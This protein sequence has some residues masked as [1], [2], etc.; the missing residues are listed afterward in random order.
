MINNDDILNAKVLIV[1]DQKTLVLILEH[2]LKKSG[3]TNI[4]STTDSTK[5]TSLYEEYQPDLILLDLMMPVK[6]GFQVLEELRELSPFDFP[7]VMVLTG[8]A[9]KENRLKALESGAR[10]F[11]NKP[12]DRLEIITRMRNL[13]NDQL[14][15]KQIRDQ[16]KILEER[17]RERTSELRET[18]LEIIRR[19]GRA[20]EYRDN[21]TGLH[22][23]RMSN[24]S[25]ILGCAAGMS[26]HDSELVLYASPL[27][28]IG[29]IAIPDSILQ[30]RG[31]LTNDE[32][33]IMKRHT[34]I[35]AK[36]LEGDSSE[37]VQLAREIALNHHEKWDGSGYPAGKKGEEIPFVGR[38]CS[39]CDVFDSLTSPRSYKKAWP[40]EEAID[41]IK[42]Q[43]GKGFDPDLVN[44]FLAYL[45]E[46]LVIKDKYKETFE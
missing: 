6:D 32:W 23:I 31:S 16:N 8:D 36:I 44:L 30:K 15:Q 24:Y 1:D 28:D 45:P 43:S 10:D 27:H 35:G 19:L 17:V 37:I 21:D 26:D 39:I 20:V 22:I 7:A 5:V 13:I 38:V 25:A 33:E 4:I 2:M 42:N 3:F 46:M 11:L 14:M 34:V 29:K 12:F 41:E 9:Q 18:Q 40:V